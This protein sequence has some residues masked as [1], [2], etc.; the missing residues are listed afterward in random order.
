MQAQPFPPALAPR[1]SLVFPNPSLTYSPPISPVLSIPE[2][3]D[4]EMQAKYS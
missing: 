3:H 4:M 1:L 2:L